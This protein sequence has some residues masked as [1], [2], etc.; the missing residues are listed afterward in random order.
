LLA[1]DIESAA[2]HWLVRQRLLRPSQFVLVPHHG[3]RTSSSAGFVRALR[4]RIAVVSAGFDNRWGFPRPEVVRRWQDEGAQVLTTGR[5]GALSTRLCIAGG[6][7][8]PIEQRRAQ[9]RYWH[10]AP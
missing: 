5:S 1:G 6:P 10:A 4:A 8:P 7:S 3:S 9:R 2:E